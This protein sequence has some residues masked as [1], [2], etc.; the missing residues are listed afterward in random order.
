MIQVTEKTYQQK[1]L[2][3]LSDNKVMVNAEEK[4]LP[5]K[6]HQ[7]DAGF[8]CKAK[9]E[10]PLTLKAGSFVTVPLGF[11][12]AIPFN[13]VG[14]IRPRSGHMSKHGVLV[15]YGT[16]D[17]GYIGEVKATL[18]N[19]SDKDFMIEDGM[20]I[21]QLVVLPLTNYAADIKKP[22]LLS[23]VEEAELPVADRGDN[24]FGSTGH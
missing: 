8:D 7:E 17:A 14:D 11:K 12:V 22:L 15:G 16:V 5:V 24:G 2:E 20:R 3:L 13:Y 1:T 10:E 21:A 23:E 9:L 6:S 4:Y 19:F 18:F